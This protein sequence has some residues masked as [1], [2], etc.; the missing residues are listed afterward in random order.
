MSGFRAPLSVLGISA[1][2]APPEELPYQGDLAIYDQAGATGAIGSGAVQ[3]AATIY[4]QAGASGAIGGGVVQAGDTI[5]DQSG[6]TG[7]I[8]GATILPPEAQR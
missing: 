4:D 3:V 6:A 1:G 5:Y 8:S 2:E 7:S